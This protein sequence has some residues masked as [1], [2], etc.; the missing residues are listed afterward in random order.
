MEVYMPP[1][2]VLRKIKRFLWLDSAPSKIAICFLQHSVY[3]AMA[4][5]FEP[6]KVLLRNLP[7]GYLMKQ[8]LPNRKQLDLSKTKAQ[9]F[10]QVPDAAHEFISLL[11]DTILALNYSSST[12][13]TYTSS[14]LKFLRDHQ[15]RDQKQLHKEIIKYLASMMERGLSASSG[16]SINALLF[17][18]SK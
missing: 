6:H 1:Y 14:F 18:I 13:R 4:M 15:F 5:Q 3:E 16:H 2:L 12:M 10:N 7:K 8:N 11:V 17:T 9:L